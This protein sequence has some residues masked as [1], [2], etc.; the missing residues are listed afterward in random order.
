MSLDFVSMF[1]G[2]LIAGSLLALARYFWQR[3][4]REQAQ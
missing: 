3:K 1:I 2:G 4:N